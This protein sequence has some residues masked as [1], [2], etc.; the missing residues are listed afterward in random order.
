MMRPP[1][2]SLVLGA[3]ALSGCPDSPTGNPKVLWLAPT[4][5]NETNVKLVDAEPPP[6]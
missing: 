4:D 1:L 5:R 3:V 6:F 2:T